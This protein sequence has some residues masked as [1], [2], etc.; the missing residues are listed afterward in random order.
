MLD[1]DARAYL[2]N[3]ITAGNTDREAL[4][5]RKRHMSDAAYRRLKADAT[6]NPAAAPEQAA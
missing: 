6:G 2:K 4:R 1:P 3:R 5:A